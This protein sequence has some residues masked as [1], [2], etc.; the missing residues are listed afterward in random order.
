LVLEISKTAGSE[1][2]LCVVGMELFTVFD[3]FPTPDYF[4]E[5]KIV[6]YVLGILCKQCDR[7]IP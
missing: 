1:S 2:W 3:K 4:E 6:K 7:V 5:P